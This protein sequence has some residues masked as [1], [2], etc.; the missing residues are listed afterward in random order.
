MRNNFI[1]TTED[2]SAHENLKL[3]MH[4]DGTRLEHDASFEVLVSAPVQIAVFCVL[5]PCRFVDK[6][7][8]FGKIYCRHFQVQN[9]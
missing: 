5:T 4:N 3:I 2:I 1:Q 8:G 6:Y 9:V 7:Q